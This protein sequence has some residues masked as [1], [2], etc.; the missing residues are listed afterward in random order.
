[1]G[2][3]QVQGLESRSVA[4]YELCPWQFLERGAEGIRCYNDFWG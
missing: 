4:F 3:F 1:M 2:H